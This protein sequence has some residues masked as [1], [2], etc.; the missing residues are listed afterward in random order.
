MF[1]KEKKDFC[2]YD[3]LKNLDVGQFSCILQVDLKCN[4]KCSY[5]RKQRETTHATRRRLHGRGS[6]DGSEAAGPGNAGSLWREGAW[7]CLIVLR[8]IDFRL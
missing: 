5:K 3:Y 6:R 8:E 2:R 4:S 7:P 1:Y